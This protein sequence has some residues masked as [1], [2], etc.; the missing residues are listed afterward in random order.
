MS[1]PLSTFGALFS[2]PALS[3]MQLQ[4]L[5]NQCNVDVM[6][7]EMMMHEGEAVRI[8]DYPWHADNACDCM[9]IPVLACLLSMM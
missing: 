7:L 9:I 3:A 1:L 6:T 2:L 4:V 8:H 5:R